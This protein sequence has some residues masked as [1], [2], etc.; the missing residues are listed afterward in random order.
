MGSLWDP[1]WDPLWD[2]LW[3][4]LG[5][6]MIILRCVGYIGPQTWVAE[7]TKLVLMGVDKTLYLHGDKQGYKWL[8]M[9]MCGVYVLFFCFTE[10][11]GI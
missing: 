10:W 3:D 6:N 1:L 11:V 2:L 4:T 5:Y 8:Q 9:E 7:L